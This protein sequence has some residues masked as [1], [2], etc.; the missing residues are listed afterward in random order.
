MRERDAC[1]FSRIRKVLRRT[2]P[3][4]KFWVETT[5]IEPILR[6]LFSVD[7]FFSASAMSAAFFFLLESFSNPLIAPR[8]RM[9]FFASAVFGALMPNDST[10]KISPSANFLESAIA[11]ALLRIFLGIARAKTLVLRGPCATPPPTQ[12]G[13]RIEPRRARPGPFL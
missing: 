3:G 1:G 6:K 7:T 10:N 12:I 11:S 8:A 4:F 5:A 2:D 13:E 9:A